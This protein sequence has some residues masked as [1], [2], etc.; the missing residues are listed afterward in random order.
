[1]IFIF[2]TTRPAVEGNL[3]I[4]VTICRER[5]YVLESDALGVNVT[6]LSIIYSC[7][8]NSCSIAEPAA[9]F[10]VE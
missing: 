4:N 5:S 3:A 2:V 9:F 7:L 6:L 1:M 8:K 10:S